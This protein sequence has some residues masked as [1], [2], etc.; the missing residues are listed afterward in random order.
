M[1]VGRFAPSCNCGLSRNHSR[2][3]AR[4]PKS[5][6]SRREILIYYDMKKLLLLF[7]FA[8]CST[9]AFANNTEPVK[10]ELAAAGVCQP[11]ST[12][13]KNDAPCTYCVPC[14][15]ILICVTCP[16]K[17]CSLAWDALIAAL[18]AASPDCCYVVTPH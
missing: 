4:M 7:V 15:N 1:W 10:K 13:E 3:R 14:K 2:S 17:D 5:G 6:K 16:C 8:A 9:M 18:C 12:L 11:T